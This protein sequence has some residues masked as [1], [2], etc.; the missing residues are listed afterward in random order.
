MQDFLGV[1]PTITDGSVIDL[2]C[3][4]VL[5]TD[6]LGTSA[7]TVV[8]MSVLVSTHVDWRYNCCLHLLH[9]IPFSKTFFWK[10][11]KK[12]FCCFDIFLLWHFSICV[13]YKTH[14]NWASLIHVIHFR[15]I[16]MLLQ[17]DD[18]CSLDLYNTCSK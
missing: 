15:V 17:F 3:G 13:F 10:V 5:F 9:M 7:G 11:S 8:T 6:D 12:C 16:D 14:N 18:N 4:V 2:F 1:L